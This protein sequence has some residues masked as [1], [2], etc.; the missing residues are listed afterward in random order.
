M[1]KHCQEATAFFVL[2]AVV[3]SGFKELMADRQQGC[4]VNAAGD[5]TVAKSTCDRDFENA[6]RHADTIDP[7]GFID[8]SIAAD[9]AAG[10]WRCLSRGWGEV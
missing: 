6:W 7:Q 9:A 2:F 1:R 10:T 4:L 8:C 5:A 3:I